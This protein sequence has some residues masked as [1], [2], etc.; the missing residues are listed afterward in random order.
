M[1]YRS[2]T[3]L[4]VLSFVS[5]TVIAQTARPAQQKLATVTSARAQEK[6]PDYAVPF[7]NKT[8][9]NGLEVIVLQDSSVPLVTVELAV[10]NGS[11]TD[12]SAAI[13]LETTGK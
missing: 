2:F 8:L 11:F 7:V 6:R 5:N 4:L 13:E 3:A 12:I 10:R 9:P 1:K